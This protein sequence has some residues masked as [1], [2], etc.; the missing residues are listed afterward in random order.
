MTA[1]RGSAKA[2]PSHAGRP[3]QESLR[4]DMAT[5]KKS[6]S[7]K[8]PPPQLQTV[9]QIPTADLQ[10][11]PENPRFYRLND[12]SNVESV[13]EEM[14]DKEGAQNLMLS[15]GQKGYFAGEP[16]LVVSKDGNAPYTV[17]EGNRRLAAVKLLNGEIPPPPR[18]KT[19]VGQIRADAAIKAFPTELPCLVYEARKD[20]LRYLGYRHITGIQE[21]DALSKARYLAELKETFYSQDSQA[22]QLKSL[23]NEIGSRSDYVAQLLT[24][25]NLYIHAESTQNFFGL[26]LSAKDVEFSYLTTAL[27]YSSICEWLGLEGKSDVKMPGLQAENLK[28]AFGWFFS[29]DQLGRTVLGESRNLSELAAVVQNPE[30]VKVLLETNQLSEAYLYSDGPQQALENAMQA[31]IDRV[32]TVWR[33]V[34]SSNAV[35]STHLEM[36]KKLAEQSR[37][38]RSAIESKLEP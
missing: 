30:A 5:A 15:I 20:V 22:S 17:V 10:F 8:V 24:A 13:V 18:R 9:R 23:A 19:S 29:K 38:V 26:P 34:P 1:L 27:N 33:M 12:A 2:D 21:W 3:I 11:D 37:L 36:A 14:L 7:P 32:N 31:A 16:L 25:L 35:T 4:K 28:R 6:R